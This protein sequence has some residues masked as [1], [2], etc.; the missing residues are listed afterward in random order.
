M[1]ITPAG[2]IGSGMIYLE[3]K[4]SAANS[5]FMK[6]SYRIARIAGIDIRVHVTFLLLLAYFAFADWHSGGSHAAA[7][8][9]IFTLLLFLCVLLHEFGHAMAGRYYGI[10][11]PDITLLPIGGVARLE[12]IPEKPLQEFVIAV[13]GPAVNLLIG[14]ALA[15]VLIV[16]GEKT[17]KSSPETWLLLQNLLLVNG[18]LIGFNL[19]PAFPM[20][21]GRMA[22]SLLAMKINYLLATKIAA[23]TGQVIAVLF[24]GAGIFFN[25]MLILIGFFV[26]NSARQELDYVA[27]REEF[28]AFRQGWQ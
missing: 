28:E 15:I 9:M 12:T 22:R 2:L 16:A 14:G 6:W 7:Q 20:D 5:I 21:G 1:V 25:P 4:L 18:A 19:I 23:R 11:T 10:R 3:G 13:A 24:V 27:R 17:Q 26:F 8:G